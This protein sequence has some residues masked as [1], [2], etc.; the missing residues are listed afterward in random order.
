MIDSAIV[1]CEVQSTSACFLSSFQLTGEQ[2]VG[3]ARQLLLQVSGADLLD[4]GV[5]LIYV[6]VIPDQHPAKVGVA[7]PSS[8]VLWIVIDGTL[9]HVV[10]L[11][12]SLGQTEIDLDKLEC[13]TYGV[14]AAFKDVAILAAGLFVFFLGVVDVAQMF[15]SCHIVW[16]SF[17]LL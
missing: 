13:Y 12:Q 2:V 4:V 17:D 7:Q 5:E 8:Q 6:L 15:S 3:G 11:A 1:F 16:L 9:Q 10:G 14:S